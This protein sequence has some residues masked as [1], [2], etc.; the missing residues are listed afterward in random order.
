MKKYYLL[1]I[2][3]FIAVQSKAQTTLPNPI[4]KLLLNGN[5]NDSSGNNLHAT[6]TNVDLTKDRFGNPNS[7]YLFKGLS[8][9]N[10]IF[11]HDSFINRNNYTFS[12]WANIDSMTSANM[13]LLS[14]GGAYN[15]NAGDAFEQ[16]ISF[17][18]GNS[19]F[20]AGSYNVGNNPVQS[21]VFTTTKARKK[22]YHII[23]TRN[24]VRLTMYVNGKKVVMNDNKSLT[25]NQAAH[26]GNATTKRAVIGS[27]AR[28][29]EY[30]FKGSIDDVYLYKQTFTDSQALELYNLQKVKTNVNNTEGPIVKLLFNKN[31]TDSSG[32]AN[33]ATN[34]GSTFSKDRYGNDS[35]AFYF[36][37][38]NDYIKIK[39]D[40]L[41]NQN[42][43]TYSAWVKVAD[44]TYGGTILAVGSRAYNQTL[45]FRVS[46][47]DGKIFDAQSY[48]HS[49]QTSYSRIKSEQ[50]ALNKWFHV[51]Y[52]RDFDRLRLYINGVQVLDSSMSYVNDNNANYGTDT[53]KFASLGNNLSGFGNSFEG[54]IDDVIIYRRRLSAMEVDSLYKSFKPL[55][56]PVVLSSKFP[57]LKLDANKNTVDSSSYQHDF[58]I[59]NISYGK[60]RYGN[61]SSAFLFN[62]NNSQIQ[63]DLDTLKPKYYTMAAWVKADTSIR[64]NSILIAYGSAT[65]FN[66]KKQKL[67]Y[68]IWNGD[69]FESYADAYSSDDTRIISAEFIKRRE[70]NHVATT[71]DSLSLK[72]FINGKL[73]NTLGNA[74]TYDSELDYGTGN[75]KL[76]I[77]HHEYDWDAGRFS[78]SM[79]DIVIYK[80][81]LTETEIDSLF[82]SYPK[83]TTP[84][85]PVK[86]NDPILSLKFSGN[87]ID[88]SK[89]G[90]HGVVYGARLTKDRFGNLN[91]AYQFDG[92][93]DYIKIK[94]NMLVGLND[95]TYSAWV[96]VDPMNF[97]SASTIFSVGG[98]YNNSPG[99]G[100]EQGISF[101]TDQ[102]TINGNKF[103]TG[104]YNEYGAS[105]VQ[106][107]IFS[108][109]LIDTNKWYHITYTR[110]SN[111]VNMYINGQLQQKDSLANTY[112]YFASYG[113]ALTKNAIVGSIARLNQYY[114]FGKIDDILAY[115]RVISK[116][117]IDSIY[118]NSKPVG[119]NN[120]QDSNIE[121]YPNPTSNYIQFNLVNEKLNNC[122]LRVINNI[123]QVVLTKS[124]FATENTLDISSIPSG[125]YLIEIELENGNK[126]KEKLII[127]RY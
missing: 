80:K 65:D 71:R 105:I 52:T 36:D 75:A 33:H 111:E 82:N 9:S 74:D 1:F 35:S 28:L 104:S 100:F 92:F 70:W 62:G 81:A 26:Y 89:Y 60:D 109:T 55:R 66:S 90:N 102:F 98:A 31:L 5:F 87:A 56:N 16:G 83:H 101:V 107:K 27:I 94:P 57:I 64:F 6:G 88:S 69:R 119:F 114:F 49:A 58:D 41:I 85:N 8:N 126:Y 43:Y 72:I 4:I 63:Y 123:G 50:K 108:T 14:I 97:A 93:D 11:P 124:N 19:V 46:N 117:E 121:I 7:A 86:I 3:L 48:N 91:S 115:N 47:W 51:T 44:N 103:F 73:V 84:P 118:N 39:H 54:W 59:A 96:L 32:Y 95:F 76:S 38:Q 127:S 45:G 24:N 122:T 30:F 120:N 99:E 116:N 110:D 17:L 18:G 79:D 106:S 42:E 112:K 12:L 113:S 22:W 67:I 2:I 125:V 37:G 21:Q 10:I 68:K 29:T 25:N 34:Y 20:F 40:S 78:G 15:Q 23:V 53:N 13:T 61:D 77:G